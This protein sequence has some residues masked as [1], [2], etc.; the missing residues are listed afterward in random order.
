MTEY[1]VAPIEQSWELIV[2][3]GEIFEAILPQPHIFEAT[4]RFI[5]A[6]D[7]IRRC[8]CH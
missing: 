2:R 6:L 3:V 7:P 8:K 5:V 1:I 4:E